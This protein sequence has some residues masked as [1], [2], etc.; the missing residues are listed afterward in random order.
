M[1]KALS[2]EAKGIE[3]LDSMEK[4]KTKKANMVSTSIPFEHTLLSAG[5]LSLKQPVES[6]NKK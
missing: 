2:G 5:S 4:M 1:N 3:L 6:R